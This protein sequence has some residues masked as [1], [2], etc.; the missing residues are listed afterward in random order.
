MT[1]DSNFTRLPTSV[2][3]INYELELQPNFDDYT[4]IG[5]VVIDINV[6]LLN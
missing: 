2:R 3:P 4:F 1:S 5:S 6:I